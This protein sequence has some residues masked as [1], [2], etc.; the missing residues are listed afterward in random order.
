MW[1]RSSAASR[2]FAWGLRRKAHLTL[3][4]ARCLSSG[5]GECSG[6]SPGVMSSL[7][8]EELVA[9]VRSKEIRF[10]ELEAALRPD[11]ERAVRV[12]RLVVQADMSRAPSGAQ[13]L[14]EGLPYKGYCYGAVHG[15]NCENVVGYLPVPVGIAGPLLLDGVLVPI[16]MATTEGALVAS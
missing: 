14:E 4:N 6:S 1:A 10:H 13:V 5:K 16:P 15:A 8:D 3:R 12:R 2:V 9:K 11:F 7:S